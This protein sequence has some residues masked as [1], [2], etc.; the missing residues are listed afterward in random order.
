MDGKD[1]RSSREVDTCTKIGSQTIV[2][3]VG[4][5]QVIYLNGDHEGGV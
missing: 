3:Q 4:G 1:S 5:D 2:S